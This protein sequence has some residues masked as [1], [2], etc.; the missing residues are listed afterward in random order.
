MWDEAEFA[1]GLEGLVAD[2][3]PQAFALVEEAGERLEGRIFAWSL[4]FEDHAE[5]VGAD[6]AFRGSF[7]SADSA[8][9]LFSHYGKMRMVWLISPPAAELDHRGWGLAEQLCGLTRRTGSTQEP[10]VR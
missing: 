5:V 6:H 4:T 9:Q 1:A 2:F 7:E 10:T 3:A 8:R